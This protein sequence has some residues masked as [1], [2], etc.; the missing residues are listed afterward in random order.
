[1]TG[2][3]RAS[4]REIANLPLDEAHLADTSAWSKARNSPEIAPQFDDSTRRGMVATCDLVALE[5]LRGAQNSERFAKQSRLLGVLRQ[6]E[7]GAAELQRA[8]QVQ[9]E[10]AAAGHQRGVKPADLLI[11]AAAEAAGLPV[12]HYDHDFD[13]IAGVTGQHARWL[14]RPGSLP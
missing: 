8:R 5:L 14:A 4:H 10:L 3:Q 1:M 2:R 6:C 13:L 9:A 7:I 12:L 11:A